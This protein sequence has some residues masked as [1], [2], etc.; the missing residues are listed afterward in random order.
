M[1]LIAGYGGTVSF[2]GQAATKCRSISINM[3]RESLD[4]TLI[5]DWI[6]KRAAGR[7]RRSGNLTLY[8]TNDSD[9]TLKSHMFPTSL[10]LATAA[11]LTLSYTD[12]GAIAYASMNIHITSATITDD[13]TGAA[14]WELAWEEQG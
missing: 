9:A 2:S 12:Q 7:V 1:A 11:T 6:T 4:V 13:G 8:R 10:A 5:G 14:V 3:E